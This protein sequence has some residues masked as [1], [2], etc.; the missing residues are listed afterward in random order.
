M[1]ITTFFFHNRQVPRIIS[2]RHTKAIHIGSCALVYLQNM[3]GQML[4][5]IY[6]ARGYSTSPT[7]I[8]R[9]C[10]SYASCSPCCSPYF[11]WW[12][13]F[14]FSPLAR[15]NQENSSPSSWTSLALAVSHVPML[16]F[17]VDPRPHILVGFNRKE[18]VT[19]RE[20]TLIGV[21]I[22]TFGPTRTLP[23]LI[24]CGRW[25]R[26]TSPSWYNH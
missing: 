1:I 3:I 14:I 7:Q 10:P 4:S 23:L 13:C 18:R 21:S 8:Y 11:L 20:V 2:W 26:R 9:P 24:W 17:V 12:G 5:Q 25:T 15:E 19:S 6:F 22:G 16:N